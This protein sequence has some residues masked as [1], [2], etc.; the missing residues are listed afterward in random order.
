MLGLHTT[1]CALTPN[2]INCY[3]SFLLHYIRGCLDTKAISCLNVIC[4][5]DAFSINTGQMLFSSPE[6]KAHG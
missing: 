4:Y 6:P 2:V 1:Q 3:K 5:F